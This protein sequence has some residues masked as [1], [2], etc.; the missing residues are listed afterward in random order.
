MVVGRRGPKKRRGSRESS[1]GG[2]FVQQ[3]KR[4]DT[5]A[6]V[7]CPLFRRDSGSVVVAI[8]QLSRAG[9]VV[10]ASECRNEVEWVVRVGL[11]GVGDGRTGGSKK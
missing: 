10:G 6:R 9:T 2:D 11:A 8:N 5:V 3:K 7:D 4:L 1:A